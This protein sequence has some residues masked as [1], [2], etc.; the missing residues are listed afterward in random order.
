MFSPTV[1]ANRVAETVSPI[2][3]VT[4]PVDSDTIGVPT[5]TGTCLWDTTKSFPMFL[6]E[7]CKRMQ[8]DKDMAVL[9]YKLSA[10]RARDP[11][12]RLSTAEDYEFAME[13]LRRKVKNARTKEHKLVLHN[14]VRVSRFFLHPSLAPN[15]S[16]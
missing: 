16:G 13:E 10:D 9:G 7:M 8:L 14:L 15:D 11:A 1:P 5:T 2:V 6:A 3:S 4:Y 12:R